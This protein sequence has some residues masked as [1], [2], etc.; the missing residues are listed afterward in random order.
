MQRGTNKVLLQ[1]AK[2][3]I[4]YIFHIWGIRST[5]KFYRKSGLAFYWGRGWVYEKRRSDDFRPK[6]ELRMAP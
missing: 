1:D 3:S 2:K 6:I 5:V 4:C